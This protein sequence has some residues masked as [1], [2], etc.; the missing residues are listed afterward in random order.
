MSVSYWMIEGIG[1]D[2][3][4]IRPHLN[5]RKVLKLILEQY[6]DDEDANEWKS[7]RDLRGFNIDDYLYG[8]LFDNLGDLLTHCDDTNTLTYGDNGDGGI[9]LYYPPSMPWH[10]VPNEPDSQKEVHRR[11]IEAVMK[12]TDLDFHTIDEMINDDIYEVG[13][14]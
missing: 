12:V 1:V 4:K 5:K 9:Y 10:R 7:R 3:E 2:V 13:C 14:G 11:I 6:P 8:N